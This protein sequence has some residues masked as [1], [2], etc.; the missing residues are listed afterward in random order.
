MKLKVVHRTSYRYVDTVTTSHHEARLTPRDGFNQRTLSHELMVYPAPETFRRRFDYFGNRTAHFSLSEPHRT[1]DV[2]AESLVEVNPVRQLALE[3]SPSWESVRDRLRND[4]RRDAL[5]AFAM[6]LD[7]THIELFSDLTQYAQP[8]FTKGRPLLVAVRELVSRIHSDFTYDA[9]ATAISTPLD[10]LLRERRGVCQD[11]AHVA[12]GC[13][14][15]Q[16]LAARYVSGY[17]LTH[18]PPGGQRL[19][20]ADASHAWFAAFVPELGWIDFD[21]TNDLI[22]SDEH[23]T[24]ALGRDFADVTPLRGVI[25]GGGQHQLE[26]SV[27]VAPTP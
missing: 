17:L 21:P 5:D 20:G 3:A 11:F 27:D 19:I 13:L 16:G 10:E 26:V 12:I 14:R 15:S 24:V 23:V 4:R 2:I 22:P 18:P 8:S 6:S 7:S 25:L 1:L 9:Q